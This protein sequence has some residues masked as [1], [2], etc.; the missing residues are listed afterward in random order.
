MLYK[1]KLHVWYNVSFK[2]WVY[3]F[4]FYLWSGDPSFNGIG[5]LKSPTIIVS[6]LISP[7]WLVLFSLYLKVPLCWIHIYSKLLDILGLTLHL[8]VVFFLLQDFYFK[9]YFAWYVYCYS[10]LLFI[11]IY[12]EYF[13][14]S[15][16]FHSACVPKSQV[17]VL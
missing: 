10:R 1:H 8:Y 9:V 15:L 14:S 17:G 6:L 4:I 16:Y 5:L 12:M 3:L 2:A 13:L 7:L 11:S